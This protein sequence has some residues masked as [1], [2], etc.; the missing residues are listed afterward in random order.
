M[1]EELKA[2]CKW[3]FSRLKY[4]NIGAPRQLQVKLKKTAEITYLKARK[5]QTR[6]RVTYLEVLKEKKRYD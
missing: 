6:Y 3:C 2:N 1:V 5:K 4:S